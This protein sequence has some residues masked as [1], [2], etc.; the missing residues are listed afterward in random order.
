MYSK[1]KITNISFT[2]NFPNKKNKLI[3]ECLEEDAE[4]LQMNIE[5]LSKVIPLRVGFHIENVPASIPN[6]IIR[7]I[8][9]WVWMPSL[10][11]QK[12]GLIYSGEGET[13]EDL[14]RDSSLL[15][16]I[17]LGQIPLNSSVLSE[18]IKTTEYFLRI[19][20]SEEE[21]QVLVGHCNPIKDEIPNLFSPI[22][23]IGIVGI[24]KT[25]VLRKIF[26]KFGQSGRF[27]PI[28][29]AVSRP[30]FPRYSLEEINQDIRN[31]A[32]PFY[33]NLD[34]GNG[35][36][37]GVEDATHYFITFCLRSCLKGKELETINNLIVA[38]CFLLIQRIEKLINI[39]NGEYDTETKIEYFDGEFS[40]LFP[41]CHTMGNILVDALYQ[42]TD[43]CKYQVDE[44]K[45]KFIIGKNDEEILRELIIK[46]LEII[47]KMFVN[48]TKIKYDE[49]KVRLMIENPLI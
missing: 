43:Y 25:L 39:L 14:L 7:S 12:D 42:E 17:I 31:R 30:V 24:G 46:K 2:S 38:S 20:R 35:Y 10:C 5:D 8:Q 22:Y 29:C 34:S 45:I 23:P 47:S 3:K 32:E 9:D 37:E 49:E 15:N 27:S 44:D 40:V 13:T 48:F 11:I 19:N 1:A 16:E 18:K 21:R 6:A 28:S 4:N 41:G 36:K 33:R 26:V